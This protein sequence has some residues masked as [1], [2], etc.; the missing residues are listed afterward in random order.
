MYLA[1]IQRHTTQ[2]RRG[3]SAGRRAR[4]LQHHRAPRRCTG[5]DGTSSCL[6]GGLSLAK[7]QGGD[8]V[9]DER[10]RLLVSFDSTRPS[11]SVGCARRAACRDERV[12][13]CG[14]CQGEKACLS[15]MARTDRLK[16]ADGSRPQEPADGGESSP[17]PPRRRCPAI[18]RFFVSRTAR[19]LTSGTEAWLQWHAH[20]GGPRHCSENDGGRAARFSAS[21]A[22]SSSARSER[23]V[24]V[25]CT[26]LVELPYDSR[27]AATVT[28]R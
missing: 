9:G 14:T 24:R 7:P 22:P 16:R 2:G 12:R 19:S 27:P 4:P 26:P 25:S 6:T 17:L 28:L 1:H 5:V 8:V 10:Q 18:A 3:T 23:F 15:C 11:D 20:E 13:E 21:V